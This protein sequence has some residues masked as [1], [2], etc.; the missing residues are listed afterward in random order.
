MPGKYLL[1][2]LIAQVLGVTGWAQTGPVPARTPYS[3]FESPQEA[4]AFLQTARIV[5]SRPLGS[6]VSGARKLLLDDGKVQHSAV[7]KDVDVH[8]HEVTIIKGV[9]EADFKD[10]WRYEVAAYELDKLL[11][12]NLIPVTVE[13]RIDEKDGS[14]QLWMDGCTT[15]AERLKSHR[16]PPDTS[17]WNRKMYKCHL[18]DNLVYNSDSNMGNTLVTPEYAIFKI[19]HT[20]AF[21]NQASL[22]NT[23]HLVSFSLSLIQAL[24]RLDKSRLRECCRKYLSSAEMDSLLKRKDLIL[25][26]YAGLLSERGESILYP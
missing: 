17:D 10:S 8:R 13:R 4:A 6:G 1:C 11:G 16:N 20:R 3:P 23:Q 12:M 25:K 14:L 24:E 15:E 26:L 5:R 7:F 9:P 22:P 2:I 21:R 19:D 18:F